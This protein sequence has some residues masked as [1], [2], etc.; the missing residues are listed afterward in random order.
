MSEIPSAG[1]SVIREGLRLPACLII[2]DGFG[3][4]PEGEGNAISLANTPVLDDLFA[5]RSWTR[6]EASGEAVGL[7]AGQMGKSEV[8]HLN[9]G[10]G[11][12]VHQELTRIDLACEDGSLATNSIIEEAFAEAKKPGAALHLMGLVSDG[13]VHSSNRHLYALIAAAIEAGVPEVLVHC[14]LDGRD[15]P[16]KIHISPHLYVLL[17]WVCLG[18]ISVVFL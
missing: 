6:L 14:F 11:R 15:V 3:L 2:M 16:P 4:Q 13:G 5:T 7:P 12:V 18:H 8:G 10:A 17:S 9:I 1:S